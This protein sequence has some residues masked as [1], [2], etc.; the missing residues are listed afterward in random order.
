[1]LFKPFKALRPV[2]NFV[3]DVISPPYDVLSSKEASEMACNNPLSFLHISKPEIDLPSDIN[4]YS[5]QVYD[6]GAEN[7]NK[8]INDKVLKKEE[9]ESFYVYRI[10]MGNH[11]QT[12]VAGL[13]SAQSYVDGNVKR[14]EFTLPVK[15]DDRFNQIKT[16]MAQTGPVLLTYKDSKDIS[17]I[18]AKVVKEKALYDVKGPN[19]TRHEIWV[20]SDEGEVSLLQSY[21]E[22]LKYLYIADGHHRMAA[23]S[24]VALELKEKFP[25][26][27]SKYDGVLAVAFSEPEMQVLPYNRV[28]KDLN[29]LSAGEIINKIKEN[30]FEVKEV[31]KAVEPASKLKFGMYLDKKWYELSYTKEVSKDPVASL[32]VSVLSDNVFNKI[33]DIVDLRKDKRI[34]FVGGIRGV[35]ELEKLVNEGS[36]KVAFSLFSTPIIDM[37]NVADSG[38]V[39]PPKSTWFEPKLA[40][41]LLS[42][43]F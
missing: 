21:F 6:K 2:E 20:L 9:K 38:N 35:K 37:I 28:I 36:F 32:D 33:F 16:L 8:L 42:N 30:G 17:G 27:V 11:T 29:G 25:N 34:A 43:Q 14:H 19:E 26:E 31:S 24:R 15:E 41:G 10:T 1:M 13:V 39:M 4:Q 12:G 18:I 7:F 3:G 23:G 5:Q 22:N 40:D